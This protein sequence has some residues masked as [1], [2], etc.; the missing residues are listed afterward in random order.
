MQVPSRM[1]GPLLA[2]HGRYF[3][4]NT[5]NLVTIPE[6]KLAIVDFSAEA[7]A[8][9]LA[10]WVALGLWSAKRRRGAVIV[11]VGGDG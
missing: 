8:E 1:R 10:R 3:E 2:L 9:S 11:L 5:K 4:I 6:D 7:A